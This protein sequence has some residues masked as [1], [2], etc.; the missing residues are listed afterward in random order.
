MRECIKEDN[1]TAIEK[2]PKLTYNYVFLFTRYDYWKNIFGEELCNS[3]QTRVYSLA[4]QG[5]RFLQTLFRLHW[6][7]RIN[8]II[9]L[10]FK[11][12]WFR[13]IYRQDFENKKPLCFV[14][15]GGNSIRFDGGLTD[16]IRKQ[17]SQN[18]QVILHMD[19]ISKKCNYD[20]E[21]LSKKVD[22]SITYDKGEAEKFGIH[23]YPMRIYA[24]QETVSEPEKFDFDLYF[25]GAVKDRF[26]QILEVYDRVSS[27]GL[28]CCFLLVGVPKEKQVERAG[29]TYSDGISY[30]ENLRYVQR[31]KCILEIGQIGAV[32][33]TL[34]LDEAVTY[35]RK[36]LTNCAAVKK[37]DYYIPETMSVFSSDKDIDLEFLRSPINYDIFRQRDIDFSPQKLLRYIDDLLKES[38]G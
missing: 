4:F 23:W 22:A 33:N 37:S 29:I 12:I 1:A 32:A 14:Y 5:N 34:R 31:T 18:R 26:K 19:L 6:S 35:H 8:K 27:T 15:L 36:L 28:C 10:P 17:S 2:M 13:K 30:E 20:Y 24:K 9:H 11:R 7:Y 16:Y 38:E 21:L 3:K 25:L